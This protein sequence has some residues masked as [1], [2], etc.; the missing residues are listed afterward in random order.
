MASRC[1]L[2]ISGDREE[3]PTP[4]AASGEIGRA[5]YAHKDICRARGST[6]GARTRPALSRP[7]ELIRHIAGH[8]IYAHKGRR[9]TKAN[10][11]G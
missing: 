11:A 8:G 5:L 4:G 10:A 9:R 1:S 6:V 7:G 3:D 2:L